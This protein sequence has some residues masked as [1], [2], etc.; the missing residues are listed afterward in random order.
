MIPFVDDPEFDKW[1]KRAKRTYNKIPDTMIVCGP[2]ILHAEELES[3]MIRY[4]TKI[5]KQIID[6]QTIL[7]QVIDRVEQ[8]TRQNT[9]SDK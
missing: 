5:L 3:R 7:A 8:V 1:L 4:D 2:E 9:E 6:A